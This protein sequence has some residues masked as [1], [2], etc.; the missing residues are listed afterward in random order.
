MNY[1]P[2]Q[3]GLALVRAALSEWKRPVRD[4][5]PGKPDDRDHIERYFTEVALPDGRSWQW[6]LDRTGGTYT[7]KTL[8]GYQE[9]CGL[10][11]AWCAM[12]RIGDH[13]EPFRSVPVALAPGVGFFVLPGTARIASR[14]KWRE[15]EVPEPLR[16][17]PADMQPGD[18]F[19]VGHGSTESHI[20]I[21]ADV[22]EHGQFATVEGNAEGMLGTFRR[23][24]GV[25]RRIRSQSDVVQLVRLGP[26]HYV[27]VAA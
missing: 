3:L 10:F 5:E 27:E 19:T 23:G 11:V 25:I 21:V 6:F 14:G 9:W 7:E 15:A 22:L 2:K 24:E 13:L 4:I 16:P 18:I 1:T 12:H 8:E 26:D 17:A 20:G